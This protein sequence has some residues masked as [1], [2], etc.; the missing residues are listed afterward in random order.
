MTRSL[1]GQLTQLRREASE[2]AAQGVTGKGSMFET[3]MLQINRVRVL[4]EWPAR[5]E[6]RVNNAYRLP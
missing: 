3:V 1:S 2:L 4:L 5:V 6:D